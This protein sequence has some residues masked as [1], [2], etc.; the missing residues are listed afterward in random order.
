MERSDLLDK[1]TLIVTAYAKAPKNTTMYENNKYMGIVLEI[2][3]KSHIIVDAE[4][5]VITE[6]VKKYFKKKMVGINFKEDI[7]PLIED[8]KENYHAP[9]QNSMIV[10]MKIAHQ[11][12]RDNCLSQ[13][14]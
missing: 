14:K 6:I 4:V 5:T 9:S 11:R 13:N 2:D 3:K 10:A 7:N 12:Y 1:E 8:I